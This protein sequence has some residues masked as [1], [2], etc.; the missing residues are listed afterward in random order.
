MQK[1]S[2]KKFKNMQYL[3]THSIDLMQINKTIQNIKPWENNP[4]IKQD[5][6]DC[7]KIC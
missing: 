4:R 3:L 1:K 5:T 2:S 7:G 6:L